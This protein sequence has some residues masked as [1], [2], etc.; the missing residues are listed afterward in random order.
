MGLIS[1]TVSLFSTDRTSAEGFFQQTVGEV[2]TQWHKTDLQDFISLW[3]LSVNWRLVTCGK[4]AVSCKYTRVA[5]I[6]E[7]I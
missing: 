1:N 4:A 3:C 5:V 7:N 6:T 2:E